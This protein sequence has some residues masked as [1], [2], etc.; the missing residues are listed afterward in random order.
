MRAE[1]ILTIAVKIERAAAEIYRLLYD[2]FKED[3]MAAY[4]WHS[5]ALEEEGMR[6]S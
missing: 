1:E 2:R 3:N 4:L 6:S 5:L